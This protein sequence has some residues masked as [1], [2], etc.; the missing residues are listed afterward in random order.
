MRSRRALGLASIGIGVIGVGLL[1][2]FDNPPGKPAPV[3]VCVD[4]TNSTDA[5]RTSYLPDLKAVAQSAAEDQ[6]HL[7]A[8]ACGPNA[9]GTVYWPVDKEFKTTVEY[10]GIHAREY[11]EEQVEKK[12]LVAGLRRLTETRS[13][14]GGTPLGEMLA[15]VARQCE[16][17]GGDCSIYMFTDGEWADK[18]IT[19]SDG[20]TRAERRNYRKTYGRRLSGLAGSQVNFI[21]VGHGTAMGE[22][23]L[24]EAE[25]V[26]AELIRDA[27]GE[28]TWST[29]L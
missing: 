12:G 7:Y 3:I 28:M 2:G 29:R 27:G 10:E 23:H 24:D 15:V 20:V 17:A 1:L 5:V 14:H 9:T 11:G 6:T 25:D 21:G 26:A 8:A 13:K 4:S 22:V 19:V 18:L 16:R